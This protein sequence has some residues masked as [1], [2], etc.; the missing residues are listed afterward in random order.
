MA[1]AGVV[2]DLQVAGVVLGSILL[3]CQ[4]VVIAV[5]QRILGMPGER[6][7][8]AIGFSGDGLDL[9]EIGGFAFAEGDDDGLREANG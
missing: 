7:V 2:R 6:L 4:G 9:L 3:D 5:L 1:L 8:V